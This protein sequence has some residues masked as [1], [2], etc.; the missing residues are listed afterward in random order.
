MSLPLPS[1]PHW[2]PTTTVAGTGDLLARRR[3][4]R[5]YPGAP[6]R[7]GAGLRRRRGPRRGPTRLRRDGRRA[8]G[9]RRRGGR[10]GRPIT[11]PSSWCR[12]S[13]APPGARRRS[14]SPAWGRA[15]G[16]PTVSWTV[17]AVVGWRRR[18][19][20]A[21]SSSAG[22]WSSPAAPSSWWAAG[23]CRRGWWWWPCSDDWNS[24]SNATLAVQRDRG[25]DGL[26]WCGRSRCRRCATTTMTARSN[27]TDWMVWS[28]ALLGHERPR[29]LGGVT[30]A[31][32][33]APSRRS[34]RGPTPDRPATADDRPRRS[35]RR[36]G[37]QQEVIEPSRLLFPSEVGEGSVS[38]L[39]P[40]WATRPC[41]PAGS[42]RP[43]HSVLSRTGT[44]F[45]HD[46]PARSP[47][48]L[49]FRRTMVAAVKV[50]TDTRREQGANDSFVA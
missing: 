12:W 13:A 49:V 6:C 48:R 31:R 2:V 21:G 42:L 11:T 33:I 26:G 10:R 39:A 32:R 36:A 8:A 45:R 43:A 50:P 16:P 27:V 47:L 30:H 40:R 20:W 46:V 19:W 28:P 35:Q 5:G 15:P 18:R 25:A 22:R 37:R 34:D 23:R 14:S 17:G 41:A 7:S 44:S 1:S 29:D 24:S 38:R 9:R 3:S 4:T